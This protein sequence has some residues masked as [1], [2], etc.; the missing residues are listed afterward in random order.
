MIKRI[1]DIGQL[2]DAVALACDVGNWEFVCEYLFKS[3]DAKCLVG[4]RLRNELRRLW[5]RI[6][7]VLWNGDDGT[8]EI[9][10]FD[11]RAFGLLEKLAPRFPVYMEVF[12][13]GN[14]TSENMSVSFYGRRDVELKAGDL[15]RLR[16]R[17]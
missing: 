17:V 4:E 13:F 6:D 9:D 5:E 15:E 10:T 7:K 16:G 3:D 14:M 8:D 12:R 2:K 1:T 11:E